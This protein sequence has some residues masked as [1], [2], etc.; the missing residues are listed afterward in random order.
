MTLGQ[1]DNV[2]AM[3]GLAVLWL[4]EDR[5]E[6]VLRARLSLS[7][8]RRFVCCFF[9]RAARWGGDSLGLIF[10]RGGGG[11]TQWSYY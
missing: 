8:A 1:D 4:N 10:F 7:F 2:Q 11:A 6:P 9:F 5:V 3:V